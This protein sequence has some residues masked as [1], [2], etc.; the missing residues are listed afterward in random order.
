ME[1]KNLKELFFN[2]KS[3]LAAKREL[4]IRIKEIETELKSYDIRAVSYD[5]IG[6]SYAISKRTE[7]DA[8]E[9]INDDKK[10]L[11]IQRINK[12]IRLINNRVL[13]V[14]NLLSI[15]SDEERKIIELK[16][17]NLYSWENICV[18]IEKSFRTC[19]KKEK[20]AFQKMFKILNYA[21]KKQ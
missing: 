12:E 14:E 21:I 2:Y 3:D 17:I 8:L 1:Y 4:E 20:E 16:Y 13:R 5:N 10:L 9:H 15:V 11:E 19:K 6:S 18:T 7:N